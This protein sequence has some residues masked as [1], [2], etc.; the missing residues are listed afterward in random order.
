MSGLIIKA[1]R[2]WTADSLNWAQDHLSHRGVATMISPDHTIDFVLLGDMCAA[3][4]CDSIILFGFGLSCSE[5]DAVKKTWQD[6]SFLNPGGARWATSLIV[7]YDKLSGNLVLRQGEMSRIPMYFYCARSS[8]F[9][10]N[11]IKA[12]SNVQDLSEIK[13]LCRGNVLRVNLKESLFS[14]EDKSGIWQRPRNVPSYELATKD[15]RVVLTDSVKELLSDTSPPPPVCLSGGVDSCIVAYLVKEHCQV[16]QAF[17]VWFHAEGLGVPDDL[18]FARLFADRMGI[19]LV[20]TRVSEGE[21]RSYLEDAIY[22][23]E[24][25]NSKLVEDSLYY[26]PLGRAL[27]KSGHYKAFHGSG[28]D[29][30]F[31]GF[32]EYLDYTD[33]EQFWQYYLEGLRGESQALLYEKHFSKWGVELLFPY[34]SLELLR[35]VWPLPRNYKV[36]QVG[37]RQ[38]RKALLRDAFRDTI[39][40]EIIEREKGI[41]RNN[42]NLKLLLQRIFPNKDDEKEYYAEVFRT[43]L[44]PKLL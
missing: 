21:V 25:A 2:F 44:Q 10:A 30:L 14:L 34:K 1:G 41:P 8:V 20:E 4:D 27:S 19:E 15:C 23:G 43:R 6:G 38:V 5:L 24:T 28:S 33:D 13:S 11:E 37:E 35:L 18:R 9:C 39:P 12:F 26:Y 3:T 29:R 40:P 31:A 32:R 16:C 36:R 22:V 7:I 42:N 17:T